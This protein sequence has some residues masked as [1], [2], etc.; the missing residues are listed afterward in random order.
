LIQLRSGDKLHFLPITVEVA[1]G[2]QVDIPCETKKYTHLIFRRFAGC[3]ICNVGLR[4]YLKALDALE[5][6]SV[7][8]IVIFHSSVEE[9]LRF[10][11]QLPIPI[12]PDPDRKLYKLFGV[13]TSFWSVGNPQTWWPAL[14]EIMR[15]GLRMPSERQNPF[16]LPADF[17][18]DQDSRVSACKYGTH[19]ADVWTSADVLKIA[20]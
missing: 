11:S 8:P 15:S 13:R 3:P 20:I 19:A 7:Q 2:S 12:I 4:S 18:I 9:T 16:V 5:V 6:S 1:D 17:L 10:Q 14:R